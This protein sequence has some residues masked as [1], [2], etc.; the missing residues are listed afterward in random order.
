MKTMGKTSKTFSAEPPSDGEAHILSQR[1]FS[2]K[3]TLIAQ[4]CQNK[5]LLRAGNGDSTSGSESEPSE[6]NLEA[7]ELVKNLPAV[8]KQLSINLEKEKEVRRKEAKLRKQDRSG[9]PM[10]GGERERWRVTT[11]ANQRNQ[12]QELEPESPFKFRKTRV[13][14]N[15]LSE[16]KEVNQDDV[17]TNPSPSKALRDALPRQPP[18]TRASMVDAVTQTERD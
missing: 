7:T 2:I 18:K 4:L 14:V 9:S 6:D 10:K 15:K 13:Q 8:D 11:T 1:A 17:S 3:K 5:E 16:I 12:P